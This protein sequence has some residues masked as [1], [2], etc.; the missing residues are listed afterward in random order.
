[1]FTRIL[2]TLAGALSGISNRSVK[3]HD[4]EIRLFERAALAYLQTRPTR[5]PPCADFGLDVTGIW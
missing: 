3:H 2:G 1:M 4:P 5:R